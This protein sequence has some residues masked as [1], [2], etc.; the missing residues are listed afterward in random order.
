MLYLFV[1]DIITYITLVVVI[2]MFTH[3]LYPIII[4]IIVYILHYSIHVCYTSYVYMYTCLLI[5]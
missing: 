1:Y 5:S 4:Y 3:T 2:C